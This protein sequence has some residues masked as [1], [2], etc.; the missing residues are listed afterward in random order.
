MKNM[1]N[2][3]TCSHRPNN[4]IYRYRKSDIIASS[5]WVISLVVGVVSSSLESYCFCPPN[6]DRQ[7]LTPLNDLPIIGLSPNPPTKYPV[8]ESRRRRKSLKINKKRAPCV[9]TRVWGV[10]GR[11]PST[12]RCDRPLTTHSHANCPVTAGRLLPAEIDG[13]A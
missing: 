2:M 3:Q 10:H 1:N 13:Y 11:A 12:G 9:P 7:T 5:E 8:L 4:A 6:A